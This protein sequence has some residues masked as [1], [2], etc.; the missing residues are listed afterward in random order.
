MTDLIHGDD[1]SE[2]LEAL[3]A[4]AHRDQEAI[5]ADL[6]AMRRLWIGLAAKLH[7]FQS[8]QLYRALG[9]RSFDE[10]LAQPDIGLENRNAYL[11]I[12]AYRTLVVEAGVDPRELEDV[13]I[14]KARAILPAVRNQDVT[15]EQA[16]ADARVLSVDDLREKYRPAGAGAPK[17]GD[18]PI[19]A[20]AGG[21]IIP[22]PEPPERVSGQV[23]PS[24]PRVCP[25]CG[26]ELA[27]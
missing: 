3:A 1:H 17:P 23:L 24:T 26:R 4:S 11:Y 6:R 5:K 7:S 20:T 8:Q 2:A 13:R 10:W 14:T 18:Q 21:E 27:A 9:Y 16:L 22:P 15:P 25:Q 19:D 12:E